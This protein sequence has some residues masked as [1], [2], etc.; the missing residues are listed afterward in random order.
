STTPARP[1]PVIALF[2]YSRGRARER[3]HLFVPRTEVVT[4]RPPGKDR[5]ED[6]EPLGSGRSDPCSRGM[7]RK[8][9]RPGGPSPV[10]NCCR[11]GGSACWAWGCR[12][13]FTAGRLRLRGGRVPGPRNLVS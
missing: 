9:R 11:S 8:G 3:D 1:R 5:F 2:F 12:S 10:G 4:G 13:S 7:E 6:Q